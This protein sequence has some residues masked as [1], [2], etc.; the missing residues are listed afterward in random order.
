MHI[1]VSSLFALEVL[2]LKGGRE[3]SGQT[4][5]SERGQLQRAE[6]AKASDASQRSRQREVAYLKPGTRQTKTPHVRN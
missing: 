3:G 2:Q 6:R 1:F 4:T 5:C